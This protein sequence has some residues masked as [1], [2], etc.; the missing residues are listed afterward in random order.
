MGYIWVLFGL[1]LVCLGRA[2]RHGD[3]LLADVRAARRLSVPRSAKAALTSTTTWPGQ[4]G[5]AAPT[6]RSWTAWLAFQT[7][8]TK[9]SQS[10][11]TQPRS[12]GTTL[13]L[14]V[15]GRG[16]LQPWPNDVTSDGRRNNH[17]HTQRPSTAERES[18]QTPNL[19]VVCMAAGLHRQTNIE[20]WGV[21]APATCICHRFGCLLFACRVAII[22][23]STVTISGALCDPDMSPQRTTDLI[24]SPTGAHRTTPHREWQARA[25]QTRKSSAWPREPPRALHARSSPPVLAEMAVRSQ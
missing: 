1:Y 17:C 23:P 14:N 6:G 15:P 10:G 20:I 8:G 11:P 19:N 13:R 7:K 25:T 16:T 21:R 12:F 24:F 4:A 18:A 5:I 9:K 22:V 2:P 3:D